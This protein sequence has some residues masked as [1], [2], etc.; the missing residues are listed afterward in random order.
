VEDYFNI[1][2][3][4]LSEG[5]LLLHPNGTISRD[6]DRFWNATDVCCD[7][8][9]SGIDDSGYLRA[10]VEEV[11]DLYAVDSQRIY[12]MGHS[13]GGFM[14]HRLACDHPDL[15]AA[16]VSIAGATYLDVSGCDAEVPVSVLQVHGTDDER[17]SY[18]G[19]IIRGNE[20]PSA[21]HTVENWIYFHGEEYAELWTLYGVDHHPRIDRD[22][23]DDIFN[24]F[25]SHSKTA[26]PEPSTGLGIC[27]SILT[28]AIFRR[29]KFPSLP[30]E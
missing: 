1:K 11:Q 6:G 12:V 7:F 19:G 4:A 14:A 21:S 13:N 22:F 15:F 23:R 10:L 3:D 17:V 20:Y 28:L 30:T 29:L 9:G 2:N 27:T 5:Y 25:D 16:V 18:W 8:D 26:V 24:Y